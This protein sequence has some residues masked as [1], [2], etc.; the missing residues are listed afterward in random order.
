MV[1]ELS[2]LDAPVIALFGLMAARAFLSGSR[3][4]LLLGGTQLAGLT[5][6]ITPYKS[7]GLY[8][9][10]LTA[11]LYLISQ[12]LTGA[13]RVSYLLPIAGFAAVV[14]ALLY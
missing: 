2:W 7:M 14:L 6:L 11:V 4:D 12:V 10:L 3:T 9:L 5:V 1:N 13:R 8:L